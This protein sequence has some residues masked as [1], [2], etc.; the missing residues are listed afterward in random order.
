L[1]LDVLLLILDNITARARDYIDNSVDLFQ[2]A[3]TCKSL[4]KPALSSLYQLVTCLVG[5]FGLSNIL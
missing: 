3:L 5:F 4:T 2:Y 1:P